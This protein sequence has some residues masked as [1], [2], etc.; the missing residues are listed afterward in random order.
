[1]YD[2]DTELVQLDEQMVV[3][4]PHCGAT[5]ELYLD[6]SVR[7]HRYVEECQVCNRPMDLRFD[8]EDGSVEIHALVA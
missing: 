3:D 8:Q 5:N 6:P 7:R 2:T 4:C 1:M